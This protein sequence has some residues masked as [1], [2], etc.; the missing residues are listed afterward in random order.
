M[1]LPNRTHHVLYRAG[2]FYVP[3]FVHLNH[4]VP[5]PGPQL[6]DGGLGPGQGGVDLLYGVWASTV[7]PIGPRVHLRPEA[8]SASTAAL[9]YSLTLGDPV[10]KGKM[11]TSAMTTARPFS[12][13]GQ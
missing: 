11:L 3:T 2:F 6:E 9:T 5:P 12:S 4:R 10:P 7:V 8:S 13:F 1:L